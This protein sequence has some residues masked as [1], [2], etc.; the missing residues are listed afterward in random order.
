MQLF[1]D[2]DHFSNDQSPGNHSTNVKQTSSAECQFFKW[3]LYRQESETLAGSGFRTKARPET[4]T[5]SRSEI[6]ARSWS[7]SLAGSGFYTLPESVADMILLDPD[8]ELMFN[9]NVGPKKKVI[10]DMMIKC[11]L[12]DLFYVPY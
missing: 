1:S 10:E 5:R 4:L 8:P 7:K 6:F 3:L 2:C 12:K 11:S 9:Q